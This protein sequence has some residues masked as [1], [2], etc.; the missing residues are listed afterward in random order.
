VDL[1]QMLV[2]GTG[3]RSDLR[4]HPPEMP[5]RLEA[6]THNLP[7]LAGFAA[8]LEW[9]ESHGQN[10][11]LTAAQR[12]GCLRLELAGI[13]GVEIF[14]ADC[15]CERVGVVSFRIKG[16][17]IG[18]AGSILNHSFEIACRAGLHCAPLIHGWIGSAPAGTLRFSVSGFTTEDE[19]SAAAE[20]VRRLARNAG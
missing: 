7:G 5:A 15:E 20:M 4:E 10:L 19:I 1:D 18:E 3:V 14:D 12:G 13:P 6:G 11:A 2:G 9:L 8:A 17:D 16:W